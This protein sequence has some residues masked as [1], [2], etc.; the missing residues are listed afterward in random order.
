MS[1]EFKKVEREHIIQGINDFKKDGMPAGFGPSSTYNLIYNNNEYP[2]K[3]IMA[4]ANHH[5]TGRKIERYFNGGIGTDCFKRY[6]EL[7]FNV[8]EKNKEQDPLAKLILLYKK[9]IAAHG[10]KKEIY[11][12]ELVERFKGRPNTKAEDFEIEVKAVDFSNLLY[13]NA[14]GVAHHIVNE[15][16]EGYR[17]RYELLFDESS[18][19]QERINNFDKGIELLYRDLDGT[20]DFPHHHDERTIATL[21]TYHN[22]EKYTFYKS[23][24]YKKFCEL[25]GIKPKKAGEK[26]VRFQIH[27]E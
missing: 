17:L 3:A 20:K 11:K 10:F 6:K 27:C 14:R 16:A 5:A 22:P 23:S 8:I 18:S 4:Y 24:F 1:M 2:P 12:W 26:Y 21:L 13:H 25:Q 9:E 15:K 7:G 19:L